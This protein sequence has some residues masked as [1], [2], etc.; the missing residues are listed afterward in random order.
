MA[1]QLKDFKPEQHPIGNDD[2]W[3]IIFVIATEII[4]SLTSV[5]SKSE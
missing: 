4:F 2:Q 5:D 1:I 3:V